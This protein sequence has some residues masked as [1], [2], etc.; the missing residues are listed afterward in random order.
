MKQVYLEAGW[1]PNPLYDE[2]VSR[3]PEGYKFTVGTSP[4]KRRASRVAKNRAP[5]WLLGKLDKIA[6]LALLRARAESLKRVPP[7]TDLIVSCGMLV[8]RRV[9]WV[10]DHEYLSLL[11][12]GN[13][14]YF[15][16]YRGFLERAFASEYCKRIICWSQVARKVVESNLDCGK[17]QDKLEVVYFAIRSKEFKKDFRNGKV[18]LLFVGSANLPGEFKIK[19][20][21]ETLEAFLLLRQQY[22]QVELVV[23]SDVPPDIKTKYGGNEGLTI[24]DTPLP[25]ERLEQEYKTA[26]IFVLPAHNTPW[27][28]PLEAM[29]YELPIVSL[30]VWGNPEIVEDGKTGLL[31]RT[32]EGLRYYTDSFMPYFGTREFMKSIESPDPAVVAD[33]AAKIGVLIENAELRRQMG[34]AGRREVEQG[35]FSIERRNAQLKRIFDE[36][37]A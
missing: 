32:S 35:K 19:G 36:A 27:M 9:P 17:F 23:R 5:Y 21:R 12:G 31:A 29:S 16:T 18:K 13:I 33:L 10:A 34:A 3:P 14:G 2:L 30:D 4:L 7:D 1:K 20:G 25:R 15:N 26:D 8:Y 24:I 22:S 37:T 28:V 11:L 6:P